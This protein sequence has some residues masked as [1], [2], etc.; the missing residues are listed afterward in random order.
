MVRLGSGHIA[1]I[2]IGMEAISKEP[3]KMIIP[4]TAKILPSIS[5]TILMLFFNIF[6]YSLL[7][8][9]PGDLCQQD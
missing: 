2:H 7:H 9:F 6:K 8:H 3:A 1:V 5:L 4:Q